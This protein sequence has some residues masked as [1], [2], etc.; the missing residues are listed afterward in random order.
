MPTDDRVRDCFR[1]DLPDATSRDEA[2][3]LAPEDDLFH[4]LLVASPCSASWDEMEGD[5]LVRRCRHCRQNVYHLSGMSEQEANVFV[6]ETEDQ[7][8]IRFHRRRDGTLLAR[9]CPVGWR[10]VRR[11]LTQAGAI[12]AGSG[13]GGALAGFLVGRFDAPHL[14]SLPLESAIVFA[15]GGGLL[16]L[17]V[18]CML[19]LLL[20]LSGCFRRPEDRVP[21]ADCR[22]PQSSAPR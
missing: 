6:R 19:A 4:H 9:D 16:G 18:G 21:I 20:S 22:I 5:A 12:V 14:G 13:V 11:R 1:A 2:D 15:L 8:R 7:L 10:A 3:A 17:H